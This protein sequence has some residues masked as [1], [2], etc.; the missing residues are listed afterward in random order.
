MPESFNDEQLL[1][2][3]A[4]GE[5]DA[6]EQLYAR[7][8]QGLFI[9]AYNILRNKTACEDI[10]QEVFVQLWQRR[11]AIRIHTSLEAYLYTAVRYSVFKHIKE[12]EAHSR[13]F[14]NLPERLQY[15]TPEDIIIEKNIRSQ[16]AF[17]VNN[18]PEKCREVYLLSREEHLS[19]HEIATRLN[20]STK[21]VENHITIALK[22]IRYGITR[23]AGLFFLFSLI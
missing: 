10:V 16:L 11:A 23:M 3:I 7:Y 2:A 19:H 12:E 14:K 17:I 8:W 13:V 6:L 15:A 5:H 4:R 18:L 9:A 22:K 20:I 21:T 1:H